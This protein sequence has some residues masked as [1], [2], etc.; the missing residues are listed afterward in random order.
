MK[1]LQIENASHILMACIIVGLSLVAFGIGISERIRLALA[2]EAF[3]LPMMIGYPLLMVS[4]VG[5]C[6]IKNIQ[7][8]KVYVPSLLAGPTAYFL[9]GVSIKLIIQGKA[10]LDNNYRMVMG[11]LLFGP[12]ATIYFFKFLIRNLF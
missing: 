5:L 11:G 12:T 9:F 4:F 10:L 6:W 3:V 1:Y 2:K 7:N 8:A